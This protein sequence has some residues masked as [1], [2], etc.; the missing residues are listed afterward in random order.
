MFKVAN[1]GMWGRATGVLEGQSHETGPVCRGLKEASS[2]GFVGSGT[3]RVSGA[4][5]AF[6]M[7]WMKVMTKHR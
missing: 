4:G 3:F 2:K 6:C 1:T 7:G 5:G